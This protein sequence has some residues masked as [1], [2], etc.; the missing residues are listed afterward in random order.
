M[1]A[2]ANDVFAKAEPVRNPDDFPR[3][4]VALTIATGRS[5]Q[6]EDCM[7]QPKQEYVMG[8]Q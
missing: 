4:M 3:E 8:S 5:P 1:T 2:W 6:L 7:Q